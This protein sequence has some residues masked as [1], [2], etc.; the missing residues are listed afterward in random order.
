MQEGAAFYYRIHGPRILIE[1]DNTQN[2]ANHIHA[3]WRDP[4]NDFGRNDLHRHYGTA[5]DSH[6]HR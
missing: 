6:G 1:F 5:P 4:A 3:L 2:S